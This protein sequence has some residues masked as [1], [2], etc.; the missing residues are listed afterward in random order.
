MTVAEFVHLIFLYQFM[1]PY[2]EW[3]SFNPV[4]T[5]S[6]LQRSKRQFRYKNSGTNLITNYQLFFR[7]GPSWV[8]M[9]WL[10]TWPFY[11][12]QLYQLVKDPPV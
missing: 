9:T 8:T 10:L 3:Y 7:R 5:E 4:N 11:A 2:K 1:V 6:I 12:I